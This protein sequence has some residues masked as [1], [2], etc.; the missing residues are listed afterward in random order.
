MENNSSVD[1][2]LVE[3]IDILSLCPDEVRVRA[4]ATDSGIRSRTDDGRESAQGHAD[5]ARR[6]HCVFYTADQSRLTHF[7]VDH[8]YP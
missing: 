6:S 8:A 5:I 1:I 7:N 4:G 2:Y 3:V